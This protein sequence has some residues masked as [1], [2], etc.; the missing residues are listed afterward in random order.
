MDD[1]S[2]PRPKVG[3]VIAPD[4]SALRVGSA[5]LIV[6]GTDTTLVRKAEIA[7]RPSRVQARSL[8]QLLYLS[9]DVYNGALQHRRD[10]WHI[11][12]NSSRP[13]S[14]SRF[15][16]FN[17]VK[18]L[19]VVCPAIGRFGITPV[20]G[21]ISRVDEAFGAFFRRVKNGETPGYPRFKSRARFRTIFY[22]TPTGWQL[23]DITPLPARKDGHPGQEVSLASLKGPPRCQQHG[24]T[25]RPT[26]AGWGD[27]P[28]NRPC[29]QVRRRLGLGGG[30]SAGSLP[31]TGFSC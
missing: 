21:A 9:G 27:D 25:S 31:M 4:Q 6:D 26:S 20:R 15:D 18:D 7:L 22:D 14:I 30:G 19:K 29:C 17:E 5:K 12:R 13:T 2:H 24:T 1:V 11:T 23:R 8:T 16:Q 10:A 28:G 3:T